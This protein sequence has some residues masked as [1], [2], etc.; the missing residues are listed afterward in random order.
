MQMMYKLDPH[1]SCDK[2]EAHTDLRSENDVDLI[3]INRPYL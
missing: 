1:P 2:V 3:A